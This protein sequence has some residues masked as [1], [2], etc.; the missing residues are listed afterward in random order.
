MIRCNTAAMCS[1]GNRGCLVDALANNAILLKLLSKI[2]KT[3][4]KVPNKTIF[5]KFTEWSQ[6]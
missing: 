2:I 3:L 5:H 6:C 4:H 1:H